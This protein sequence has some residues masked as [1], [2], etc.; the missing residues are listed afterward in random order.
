MS[1]YN[2]NI[3]LPLYNVLVYNQMYIMKYTIYNY[4]IYKQ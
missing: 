4:I 2:D 1:L 3:S